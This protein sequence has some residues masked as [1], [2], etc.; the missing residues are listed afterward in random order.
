MIEKREFLSIDNSN[1]TFVVFATAPRHG[2]CLFEHVILPSNDSD[3]NSTKN[4]SMSYIKTT[5][6]NLSSA[7]PMA[8]PFDEFPTSTM[9]IPNIPS[10]AQG[11]DKTKQLYQD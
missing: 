7:V 11:F 3:I 6:T 5:K 9:V 10:D 2:K 1:S 4:I 8:R